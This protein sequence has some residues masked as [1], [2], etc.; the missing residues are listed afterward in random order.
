MAYIPK[1][2]NLSHSPGTLSRLIFHYN[3][4]CETDSD[5]L[6]ELVS[7]LAT[8]FGN[9]GP[10]HNDIPG[11]WKEGFSA[12]FHRREV[13]RSCGRKGEIGTVV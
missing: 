2:G 10:T 5:Q 9:E 1:I 7:D 3:T 12:H 8:H 11:T 6:M 13:E 4:M